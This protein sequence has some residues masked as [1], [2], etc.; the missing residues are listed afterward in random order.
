MSLFFNYDNAVCENGNSPFSYD[1]MVYSLKE[2]L[3]Y[4]LSQVSYYSV[5]LEKNGENVKDIDDKTVKYIYLIFTNKDYSQNTLLSAIKEIYDFIEETEIKYKKSCEEKGIEYAPVTGERIFLGQKGKKRHNSAIRYGE[6]R[7]IYKN[8]KLS[9]T[10]KNISDIAGVL[11]VNAVENIEELIN[12]GYDGDEFKHSFA[13]ILYYVNYSEE[14]DEFLKNKLLEFSNT[15]NEISLKLR[16]I[17]IEKYGPVQKTAVSLDTKPGKA[18]LVSGR[19]YKNLE[20]LLECLKGKNIDVYT[21]GEM[22]FAHALKAFQKY[23]N[24]KGHYQKSL[25]NYRADFAAFPGPVLVTGNSFD[26]TDTIRGRIFTTAENNSYGTSRISRDDFS[27]II[28]T[29]KN[30]KGFKKNVQKGKI[31][32]GYDEKELE[33]KLSGVLERINT[34]KTKHLFITGLKI[35]NLEQKE[36][37]DEFL[38]ILPDDCEVI[39]FSQGK[40]QKNIYYTGSYVNSTAMYFLINELK[41]KFTVEE[42]K[43]TVILP[44]CSTETISFALNL[45]NLKIKN[46]FIGKCCPNAMSP[47]VREGLKDIFGIRELSDVWNDFG[48]IF[49]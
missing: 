4:E 45:V 47:S 12:Y 48:E 41:E 13:E 43:I 15:I 36:Y 11:M 46:I 26:N 24:L 44:G 28:E 1:P 29:A 14:N 22:I 18:I 6:R 49:D 21:H 17:I 34:N 27:E 8:T 5:K 32:A 7:I 38:K 25:S 3:L 37:F 42:D 23:E 2:L 19:F 16:E 39:S 35:Y 30:S 31:Q 10:K 20:I 40:N 9:K 33:I